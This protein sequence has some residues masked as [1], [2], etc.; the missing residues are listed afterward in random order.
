MENAVKSPIEMMYQW[1]QETPDHIFLRQPSNLEWTEYTWRQ[2]ADEV[3]R[4]TSYIR[5]QELEPGSRIGIWSSNSKDWVIVDLA[6]M[7]S[8]NISVPLYPG[9]DVESAQYIFE[10]S[11]TVLLFVGG[12]D[13]ADRV[14]EALAR[15]IPRVAMLGCTVECATSLKDIIAN[16]EP[17]A[18]SPIPN[19]EDIFTMLYT[20]GTTGN[21]KGVM[22]MHQTPG[23]VVPD[24]IEGLRMTEPV[25]RFFSF[26]PM[27]HAAE[28]I[29]VEMTALYCNGTISFSE[30]L[31]TF[32]D[33][34]RSVQP[35]F[36][37]AVPRLW[38]KF[39]EG[40][41]AM[42][43]AEAQ[44]QLTQEQKKDIAKHLG[45]GSARII[46]TGSAPCSK[47]VQDWF[48]D[49]GIIL[50]DA[51]GMTENFI[52]GVGWI[53]N[54][55]PIAG[56]IGLPM[57][58]SVEVKLSDE[59]EIMFRSKGLMKGY[60][61]ESE[62]TA[63]VL[64]DGWYLTGDAGKFD[65]D[66]NLWITGRVSEVFK[67]SKGKFIRPTRIEDLFGRS[68][69]LGQFCIMG[70][71]LDQPML[72]ATLSEAG[73]E[74]DEA[75]LIDKLS[76]LLQEVNEELPAWEKVAQVFITP[77]WLIENGLLTP[78]MKLKRKYIEKLYRAN[79]EE[80]LGGDKINVV[81]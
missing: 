79:V 60:Y 32:G 35:T 3:R 14:D 24:L 39:K 74:L 25:N 46:L 66:G 13:Q 26:L 69:E 45:F 53:H 16:Y 11:E 41:D 30:G 19:P 77:E 55:T 31:A 57:G 81:S 1:E 52:H 28:R 58:D 7:L 70:H 40:V 72:L 5:A 61:R 50:R 8:G 17:F 78:T 68:A 65:E 80:N 73:A 9:Q 2:I 18:E 4:I 75:T 54:D 47:D 23:Y 64:V 36:F 34:I 20:S 27:S 51:Y 44:A 29:V 67:T 15:E 42:I 38:V 76:A 63:E 37:F 49:M 22:H 21:P 43:P 12:F 59:G 33:E 56:C 48:M 62:K 71:G 10:H 6:I